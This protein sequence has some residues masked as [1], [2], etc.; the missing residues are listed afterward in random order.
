MNRFATFF[1][2]FVLLSFLSDD[3]TASQTGNWRPKSSTALVDMA[4]NDLLHV[5]L[6][7]NC[8]ATITPNMV[9]EDMIGVNADY[10]ITVSLN[11]IMQPDLIFGSADINLTFDYKIRHIASGN[12]CWGKFKIEDKYPPLMRCSNDTVRCAASISP[13]VLGYPIPRWLSTT[14]TIISTNPPIYNVIGW[15]KCSA[16]KLTYSDNVRNLTCDSAYIRKIIRT[17]TASDAQGNTST[18]M[19][20]ICII[21]PTAADIV[22]PKH[23][24]GHPSPSLPYLKC[25]D[26][27]PKLANGNP[28]P[29]F[30]GFPIPTGCTT[31]NASYSDLKIPVCDGSYKLVR[32]WVIL[33]WCNGEII[34]YD[35]I[36][37]VIDDIPPTVECPAQFTI[38]MQAYQCKG[39]T[40][41][42]PPTSVLD[43]GK[44]TYDVFVK[45][46]EPGTGDPGGPSKLYVQYDPIT[47]SFSLVDVPEGRIWII[48]IVTDDCG[49]STECATEIGVVDNLYP[50]AVCD[51]KTV[52]SLGIDGT[53]SA[54]ASTFDAG[55]LDNCGIKGYKVRRMT[56][57]C[58]NR[59]N[60]FGDHVDFCCDDVNKVIMVAFEVEDTYGNK[61][62]CMVEAT[63]QDKIAPIII[64]PSDITIS[65]E[66]DYSNINVFGSVRR[67]EAERKNIIIRDF[68]YSSPDFIAGIDGLVKDNCAVTLKDTFILDINCHKGTI[69]RIFTAVDPQ[70]LTA[71][72]VQKIYVVNNRPFTRANIIFPT[73][74]DIP[75]CTNVDTHPDNTGYP[76]YT[77][78]GCA[79]VA[80]NY[81]D[82]KLTFV[83]SVCYKILRKWTVLDW[84]QYNSVTG[85]GI[86]EETQLIYVSNSNP[87]T[88]TSCGTVE[89]CDQLSYYSN[90]I[91]YGNYDL[92][93][94][95]YDDCTDEPDLV[96]SY[97]LDAN[98]DGTFDPSVN[99]KRAVGALPLGTHRI[100][101]NVTDKCGNNSTCDQVFIL[102]DC[103]KPT[104]YCLNGIVTVVMPIAKSVS[105]W[106]KDYNVNSTDNCTQA[107]K[108]KFSFSPNVNDTQLRL[109][110]DSLQGMT[111][112][113]IKVKIY[114]TDESGNQ[115]Y[116]E[117][118][119]KLQD[120]NNTCGGTLLQY[121]G[122]IS[123]SNNAAISAVDVEL[124]HASNN[125][126]IQTTSTNPQGIYAFNSIIP[127][128]YKL[129]ANRQDDVLNGVSTFDIL[130]IQKHILGTKT[131][132]DPYMLIA[133]DVNSSASV[134]ARD[135]ADIRKLIL[136]VTDHFPNNKIW[137]FI[138]KN[139][140]F[141][142][143]T[144]PY[145]FVEFLM[146]TD[147]LNTGDK[148]SFVG[149]KMGDIDQSAKAFGIS[150]SRNNNNTVLILEEQR[151]QSSDIYKIDVYADRAMNM[152]GM[153][154]AIQSTDASLS[155]QSIESKAL[156]I[157]SEQWNLD[158]NLLKL[159]LDLNNSMQ[160][161][162]KQ[163][164][165]T[166]LVKSA[167]HNPSAYLQ[168]NNQKIS[169][170][171]YLA[172]GQKSDIVMR[173]E[174]ARIQE[175][176]FLSNN[177][178]PFTD[179]TT[180]RFE[181]T[182][183]NPVSIK[184][185]NVTGN[186]SY[187][188]Q[189]AAVAGLNELVIDR[190]QLKNAGIYFYEIENAN[191][192]ILQRMIVID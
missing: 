25:S 1:S 75:S 163:I 135:I 7:T 19:D 152:E 56:D 158:N 42:P 77:N 148:N 160:V 110:C 28:S 22:Y 95:G 24:D 68:S 119:V 32:R 175:L 70:G 112:R 151:N 85:A 96:W 137:S 150:Q 65:C 51:Q 74:R 2:I 141:K 100:R 174:S 4:C 106:A 71:V 169:A 161:K 55:S 162:A 115:D 157:K 143:K 173:S 124:L 131:I 111:T 50:I 49:N 69:T 166:I 82:L 142:D 183:D 8:Y 105:I 164:L 109:T 186:L 128:V 146:T 179:N 80:A 92:T 39:T 118:Y 67:S 59:T 84:C 36:I 10:A 54:A 139:F 104:P 43:C 185:F 99:R 122:N 165:F 168:L 27:F 47:K 132:T 184:I 41:I 13:S 93:G 117:S 147:N 23:Y 178:N 57:P 177:P 123:K 18:C 154:L 48:Y 101:W 30:T 191:S 107:D 156:N 144:E 126:V 140:E 88:V 90:G 188:K 170:E 138:P 20:T 38:G 130:Q 44:W 120:N 176:R 159:S 76:R 31:L 125:Q 180:I 14:L 6:D 134:T 190:S 33:N 16:V 81:E 29:T 3:I 62:T 60:V 145:D 86:W 66:F 133:A 97:R 78:V 63:V 94:A 192:K 114:V 181:S 102:S 91:C 40:K 127:G 9:L 113:I 83:D 53:A 34:N 189:F 35:Q 89:F 167:K 155:I 58:N 121:G 45:L 87:P 171:L 37:K 21:K 64:P 108:L 103:K 12:S 98:N 116:C 172:S 17:W 153:Q 73:R 129:K 182:Y 79:Q 15:D 187:E 26:T 149:V 11:S 46:R 5:S 52:I 136:G 72:A 61:N